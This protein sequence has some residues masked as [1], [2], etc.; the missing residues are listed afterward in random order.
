MAKADAVKESIARSWYKGDW[1]KHPFDETTDPK[2]GDYDTNGKYSWMKAPRY[3]QLP[4]EVGPLARVLVAYGY[5]KPQFQAIVDQTL[6]HLNI[7]ATALFSTL[8]RTAARAMETVVIGDAMEGWLM[9]LVGNL[10]KG[11]NKTYQSWKMPDKARGF[12]L[13]DVA[14]GSLGH[15]IEIEDQKIKNYQYVVPS[16]WNLGPR[17][18]QGKLGPVE[19]SLI[20]TPIADP[21]RPLEILRTVHSFDPCIAC[22]VHVM[23]PESNQVYKIRVV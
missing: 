3:D 16:T 21:K 18:A 22:A 2:H 17:C 9:E 10:K 1:S 13:N 11:D 5:G 23:D 6:K 12:A 14:R 20:G 15:W 7:P 8:G 4:C 19:E